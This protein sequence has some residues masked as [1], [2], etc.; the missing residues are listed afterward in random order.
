MDVEKKDVSEEKV[1][2]KKKK[3]KK[4]KKDVKASFNIDAPDF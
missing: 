2:K 1:D 3:S 4:A